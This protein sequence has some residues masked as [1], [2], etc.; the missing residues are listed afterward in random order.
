MRAPDRRRG[1]IAAACLSVLLAACSS[2]AAPRLAA[3]TSATSHPSVS[4]TGSPTPGG[5]ITAPDG[6]PVYAHVR[7]GDLSPVART[8]R[9]LVYVPDQQSGRVDI[10]DPHTYRVIGRIPV[11]AS[12]EHVVPSYDLRTLWV[13]S[14]AGYRLT[15]IDPRTGR[16]GTAV[17]VDFPY[18]LYFTPDGRY[19]LVMAE[20]L[21]RIDVRDP[22]TMRLIRSLRVPCAGVNH[23][24]YNAGLTTLMVSCEFSG[25]LLVIDSN[26]TRIRK[27][28]DLNAIRTPGAT[29]PQMA[30]RM[31][32]PRAELKP[33]ASSMPQD[34]RLSPNGRWL[35]AA[36]MLRNGVWVIDA[37]TFAVDRFVPTGFGAHG[38][39]PSRDGTR[40][41]VSNRDEGSVSV[42][43]AN[44]LKPVAK[45]RIPGGGSPDM[46]G[47]SAD[48]TQL[49]LS[50]RYNSVVYVF[51]TRTGRVLHEIPVG[52]GPHGLLIWPQP[53]RFSLGHT[54][55]MR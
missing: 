14:D 54:G 47:V 29:S 27:V 16:A 55:N 40:I 4:T 36:D 22:H 5:A 52:A 33:G 2:G 13:N 9:Q 38:I 8:A 30:K 43:D 1:I 24:D 53:G 7:P 42:L 12:P 21:D 49:W 41:Y 20:K 31:G 25:K 26:V 17:T 39:Y 46:G 51:D 32:G 15:P 11:A 48:G 19:A 6:L 44:T 35:L 50:G 45:W 23:A 10:I 18:N 3:S 34:V 37:R 28:I